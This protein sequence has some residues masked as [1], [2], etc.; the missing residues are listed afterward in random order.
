MDTCNK[1]HIKFMICFSGDFFFFLKKSPMSL[2]T[3]IKSTPSADQGNEIL[4]GELSY[5]NKDYGT[6]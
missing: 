6:W 2:L 3:L 4:G 1:A 5:R